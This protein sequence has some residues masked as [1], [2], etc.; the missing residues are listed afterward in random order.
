M[1]QN[2]VE[3]GILSIARG[4]VGKAVEITFVVKHNTRNACKIQHLDS[5][6]LDLRMATQPSQS[7]FLILCGRRPVNFD[8]SW[9]QDR[10]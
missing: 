3:K 1:E 6:G 2:G 10:A 8:F 5:K 4:F 9:P 7:A